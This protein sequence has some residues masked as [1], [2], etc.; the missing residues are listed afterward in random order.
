MYI[1]HIPFPF[2]YRI[3]EHLSRR[4][5]R[6]AQTRYRSATVVKWWVRLTFAPTRLHWL[7][8]RARWLLLSGTLRRRGVSTS[9]PRQSSTPSSRKARSLPH[10][11]HTDSLEKKPTSLVHKSMNQ[12]QNPPTP[13]LRFLQ[14]KS[15]FKQ[16]M[17]PHEPSIPFPMI[18][19]NC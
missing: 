19:T 3:H 4:R 1:H 7:R 10:Q 9:W 16:M 13:P 15:G 12:R 2:P 18:W 8:V 14:L 17:I 11:F 6:G 5:S